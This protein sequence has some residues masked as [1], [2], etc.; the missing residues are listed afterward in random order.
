MGNYNFNK[1]LPIAKNTEQNVAN[2]LAQMGFT[3]LDTNDTNAYDLRVRHGDDELKIEVK[4]DFRCAETGNVAVESFCR[5]KPSGISVTQADLYAYVIHRPDRTVL[6]LT[7]VDD[8]RSAIEENRFHRK[9]DDSGDRGSNTVNYLF[10]VD[11]FINL[12]LMQMQ[13]G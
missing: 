9:V 3:I 8:I 1:D 10:K 4:E 6:T 12:S 13:M 2:V 5:G 11:K 7:H